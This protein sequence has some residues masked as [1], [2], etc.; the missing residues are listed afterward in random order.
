MSSNN[1]LRDI[2]ENCGMNFPSKL[3]VAARQLSPIFFMKRL[4][5]GATVSGV[6]GELLKV[7]SQQLNFSYEIVKPADKNWGSLDGHGN[8]TGVM[9]MLLRG[10]ADMGLS[11]FSITEERVRVVDFS[12]PYD[13][14]DRTFATAQPGAFPKMASFT[15]PF[16]T[17]V[18]IFIFCLIAMAPLL[19]RALI[20]KKR[21]V[22][23][24]YIM[25]LGSMLKQPINDSEQS[26][27]R[28]LVYGIW[29]VSMTFMYF[30]YSGVLL[31]YLTIPWQRKGIQTIKELADALAARTHKCLAPKGTIDIEILLNSTFDYYKEIGN[32]IQQNNWFYDPDDMKNQ[33]LDD[34]KALIGPRSLLHA[35]FGYEPFTISS[36]SSDSFG[37]WNIAIALRKDFCCIKQL[38]HAILRT[39]SVGLYDKW[40]KD[41]Y[42]SNLK[43]MLKLRPNDNN[44]PLPLGDFYGVFIL[45]F[46][47]YALAFVVFFLEIYA[48]YFKKMDAE[49]NRLV[50]SEEITLEL[51]SE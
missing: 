16:N 11:H 8:W 39:L 22:S 46:V 6:E 40:W 15:Y 32:I 49:K 44:T 45:L 5:K 51:Q 31:S 29:I 4:K 47:G 43:L 3:R 30:A 28:R 36:V 12:F 18:W 48:H 14:L 42:L 41:V 38:N 24:V 34:G 19:F 21:S 35:H 50:E 23:S 1:S 10:E 20:F 25:I 26:C 9:G 7:L 2:D 37:V 17:N 33:V 13:I 27:M